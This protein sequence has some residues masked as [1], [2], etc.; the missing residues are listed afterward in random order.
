MADT[1]QT[2]VVEGLL[3]D[4]PVPVS[5]VKLGTWPN[6]FIKV[7]F[8]TALQPVPAP[9]F[10]RKAWVVYYNNWSTTLL[11]GCYIQGHDVWLR[12]QNLQPRIRDDTVS[13]NRL[14]EQVKA[15]SDGAPAELFAFF[16]IG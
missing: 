10:Y 16:P 13:Y 15:L 5:A 7:T 12:F 11:P 4:T 3:P 8:N 2:F 6:W 9:E 14:Q 1:P